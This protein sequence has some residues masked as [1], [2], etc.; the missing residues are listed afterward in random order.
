M[1]SKIFFSG[2]MMLVFHSEPVRTDQI[3]SN[4]FQSAPAPPS[5]GV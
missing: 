1:S 4:A 2:E 5:D 3:M